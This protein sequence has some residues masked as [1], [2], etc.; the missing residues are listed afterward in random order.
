MALAS[1]DRL[2]RYQIAA[3]LGKGG[4]GEVYRATDT[5]LER[6]V[7]VKVLPESVA[8]DPDRLARFE[9]E[10]KAVA[11][12]AHPNILEIWDFATD[13]GIAYAVTELLEGNNLRDEL[14]A[15]PLPW[16]RAREIAAAVADGLAAAHGKGIVHRDLKPENI[17]I[18]V[19]GRVKILDFGLARFG[20]P[21]STEADTG[22][23]TP[24]DTQRGVI[25]GTLGYIS[26]EQLKGE[27]AD[28]RADIFSLGCVLYEMLSG[29]RAFVRDSAVETMAAI[30]KEDPPRFATTG[31]A[32]STELARTVERCL[33]KRPERRFQSA[34]DLAFA[35]RAIV[36]DS[37]VPGTAPQVA[38]AARPRRWRTWLW[39]AVAVLVVTLGAVAG[40][41]LLST[42]EPAPVTPPE[43]PAGPSPFVKEWVVTVEPFENRTGD[44]TLDVA[45]RELADLVAESVNRVTQGFPSLPPVTVLAGRPGGAGDAPPA[46][47]LSE[48]LGRMLVTGSYTAGGRGLEVVA[49][50]RDQDGTR[51]L[52]TSGRFAVGRPVTGE[53]LEPL[54]AQVMGAV[55]MQLVFGL[56]HVSH[57]PDYPVFREF[58]G[59]RDMLYTVSPRR[60]C[61]QLQTT[62]EQDPEFLQVALLGAFSA[63]VARRSDEA[64]ELLTHVRERASRLTPFESAYL[65]LLTAWSQGELFRA[66]TAARTLQQINPGYFPAPAYRGILAM[67]LNR[68]REMVEAGEEIVRT[69]PPMFAQSRRGGEGGLFEAYRALGQ[70]DKLL[71]LAQRVRREKPGDTVAFEQEARA[72]A[73]LG[74][75]DELDDL[76]E[77]CRAT[78]GGECDAARVAVEAAWFLEAYDHHQLALEYADRAATDYEG[79]DDQDPRYHPIYYLFALRAAERWDEYAKLAARCVEELPDHR[80]LPYFRCCVGMAAAHRGNRETAKT[81]ARQ[82]ES[83]GQLTLAGYVIAHLGER[84]R[85]VELLRRG[86]AEASN[87]YQQLR[88]WDLDLQPLWGYPPFEELLR[89]KG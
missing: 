77:E 4:M 66:L 15:G 62:L 26:P 31:V 72:L 38:P 61:E 23:L 46:E 53:R 25:L 49:Q 24:A 9:R 81:I 33:E 34:A 10:A 83:E 55:G 30:L 52:Y 14:G 37:D 84:E 50:I 82:L 51:V 58:V 69:V 35:L 22:T 6:E 75:L 54:L 70:Y 64:A 40:W 29:Q 67:Q 8:E 1:G 76:V 44:P 71:A 19:D 21:V 2:G 79:M 27:P 45:G 60:R 16:R 13:R 80:E 5:T 43:T 89:P 41:R 57:V 73:A 68:P 63:T 48:G 20:G 28:A 86:L 7:A 78:P 12:L 32:V 36:S 59:C 42:T 56:Q 87:T 88:Q 17:V 39:A 85:A 65:E 47:P 74:R 18:T 11:R 3:P